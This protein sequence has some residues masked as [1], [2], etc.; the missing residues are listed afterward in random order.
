MIL[1]GNRGSKGAATKLGPW[2][3]LI[4]AATYLVIPTA[5][6]ALGG[7]AAW[8]QA[9]AY[10]ALVMAAGLLG[11]YLGEKRHPGLLAERMHFIKADVKP[12]DRVLSPLMALSVAYPLV[13]VAGLDHRCKWSPAFPAWL[14]GLGLALVAA[15][16]FFAAWALVENRFFS[17]VVRIQKDRGHEVCDTGPYG[18]V[19]HPGYAGNILALFG[20]VLAFGSLWTAIPACFALAV[21]LART[22]LED[23]ALG[24]ELPGYRDYAAR[25]RWRLFPGIF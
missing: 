16:Y 13:V 3:W 2:R 12:W 20:M 17:S 4:L 25:V 7:D 19:R 8:W 9:W 10:S 21:A 5:L 11:R 18:M 24:K 1:K 14:T 23:R 15:G 6:L 22:I